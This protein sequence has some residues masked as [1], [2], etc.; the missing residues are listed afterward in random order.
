MVR[1][2]IQLTPEQH[3]RLRETA[4]ARGVSMARVV[5]E[6]VE[7]VLERRA[8]PDRWALFMSAVGAVHDRRGPHDVARNHDKY[9]A[10]IYA[11]RRRLR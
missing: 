10:E 9:L 7:Q 11:G 2:Q 5:R 8:G 1:T 6:G 3:R 4:S